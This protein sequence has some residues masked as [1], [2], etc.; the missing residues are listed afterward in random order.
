M[1]TILDE[2]ILASQS[3]SAEKRYFDRYDKEHEM[4]CGCKRCSKDADDSEIIG[5]D[6]R[7]RIRSTSKAPFRYI[8]SIEYD[9]FPGCTGTLI[10]PQTLLTAAHCVWDDDLDRKINLRN[11]T[12]RIIPGRNDGSEPFGSTT[13]Q[14]IIPA[15]GYRASLATSAKDYA[16]IH[17]KD[18]IG[19]K[20]GFWSFGHK[21]R[22]FD[23]TGT[24]ILPG[25]LPLRAGVLKVNLSGY[26]G[27]KGGKKQYW[28]YNR[29]VLKKSGV[30]HYLNDTRAGHSGSPVWVRRHSSMGG[31]V[32]VG[33]HVAADDGRGTKANRAVFMGV[34]LRNFI[35]KHLK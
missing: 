2:V 28:T 7:R 15:S 30:L 16:I 31:R 14:K 29:T 17:L 1:R 10:G 21:K 5:Y 26:P 12:I 11:T 23:P 6:S 4:G 3:N 24:S 25:G 32:L 34:E 13:A 19:H 8:C 35:R 27:D 18:P 22:S 9:G 20:V 33:V